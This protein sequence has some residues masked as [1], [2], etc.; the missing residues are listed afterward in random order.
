MRLLFLGDVGLAQDALLVKKWPVPLGIDPGNNKKVLL[1]WEIPIG[2]RLN[3]VPR[4]SGPRLL[5]SPRSL[6][7]IQDWSPGF[8]T[9]ATNHILDGG[10][11]ALDDTIE[12]LNG[13]GFET[14]GAGRCREE[15]TRP[16]L[17]E[18]SEG[19]LAIINWV[20]PETHPDWMRELG[21]NCWP[22][23]KE[24]KDEIQNLKLKVD[25][26]MVVVHWSDELFAYPRP[27]D[28]IIARAISEAGADIIVGHH[29]HVVRGMEIINQTPVFYSL[30]NY[31]FSRLVDANGVAIWRETPRNR[32]GL[33]LQVTFRRGQLPEYNTVSF[34]NKGTQSVH[35]FKDRANKRMQQ[36]SSR[37]QGASYSEYAEW[38]KVRCALFDRWDYRWQFGIWN[39]NKTTFKRQLLWMRDRCL[40]MQNA[41]K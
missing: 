28:R 2:I 9:L 4:S 10:S 40:R 23:I 24:A 7:I 36:G 32:E 25:W 3:P 31:Y 37:L 1:N 14:V 18:T 30:G 38:Y 33:G 15:I 34:W 11:E 29:P 26:V 5:A 16:L 12:M 20:F 6:N 13:A 22:G 19:R 39:A 21:P 27:E 41:F 17:W 8:A 35:D